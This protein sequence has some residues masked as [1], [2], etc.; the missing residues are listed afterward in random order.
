MERY[1]DNEHLETRQ[2]GS[3]QDLIANELDDLDFSDLIHISDE[4]AVQ[5]RLHKPT[6]E[7]EKAPKT[8]ESASVHQE[9]SEQEVHETTSAQ[10]FTATSYDDVFSILIIF[11]MTSM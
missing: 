11:S 3:L 7:T 8:V 2:Y 5:H 10:R 6:K 9:V 1:L 4:D